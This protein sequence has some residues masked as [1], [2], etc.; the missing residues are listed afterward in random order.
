MKNNFI[1]KYGIHIEYEGFFTPKKILEIETNLIKIR[2]KKFSPKEENIF[3]ALTHPISKL[4]VAILG[5][6]PYFQENAAT[7][8]A[9]EVGTL[10]SFTAPFPQRSLQNI[11]RVIYSSYQGKIKKFSEIKDSII[12]SDFN[13]LPPDKLFKSWNNQGVLLLN[14]YL[15]VEF[16]EGSNTG[17]THKELWEKFSKELIFYI[18]SK[19]NNIT[20]FLWGA[21]AQK[22]EKYI[23]K[24][25]VYKCNHPAMA[26][27]KTENDFLFFQGFEKTK[28]IIN[29]CGI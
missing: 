19:N 7:G 2:E 6:D 3:A 8:L 12:S 21:H 23:F 10:N 9:F 11:I 29:W 25:T 18:S 5:Q 4:K 22:Y 16:S 28:N 15:S 17:T 14:S 24:G 26:F 20:Y 27:G 1:E 13:I